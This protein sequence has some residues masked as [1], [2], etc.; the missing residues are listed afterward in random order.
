PRGEA[1]DG[2]R[3]AGQRPWGPGFQ[4]TEHRLRG[5]EGVGERR[6]GF[7]CARR[8]FADAVRLVGIRQRL[9]GLAG[10]D[11][12]LAVAAE[13]LGKEELERVGRGLAGG[14][15]RLPKAPAPER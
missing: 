7:L 10:D 2:T 11:A 8:G 15:M 14:E 4:R 6:I 9:L 13:T 3:I 5:L 12:D 1:D